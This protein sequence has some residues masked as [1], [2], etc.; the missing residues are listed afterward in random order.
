V[1]AAS[2]VLPAP[3][4]AGAR[5][6]LTHLLPFV[7]PVCGPPPSPSCAGRIEQA[8]ELATVS[9]PTGTHHPLLPLSSLSSL[10][11][12]YLPTPPQPPGSSHAHR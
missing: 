6:H 10:P 4:F 11:P 8:G 12:P 9:L 7:V 3:R 2:S 1:H 5:P